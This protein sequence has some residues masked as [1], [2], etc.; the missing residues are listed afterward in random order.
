M[1]CVSTD[2]Q[3]LTRT[4]DDQVRINISAAVAQGKS[5]SQQPLALMLGTA[6]E[7]K[8]G[9]AAV[10][11]VLQQEGF[12]QQQA[13]R[14]VVTHAEISGKGKLLLAARALRELVAVRVKGGRP[15]VHAHCSS[16]ASFY[17][18]SVLLAL[19]RLMGCK[20]IF[21]LHGG[22]FR[23]FTMQEVGP[24]RRWWIRHTLEASSAV[25]A[26]SPSWAEFLTTFAP[27]SSV[28]VVPNSVRLADLSLDEKEEEGR[29]LF[30]GRIEKKKG[31]FELIEAVASLRE[32]HPSICLVL[33]GEGALGE[34]RA[35]AAELGIADR[36]ELPGWV[37]ASRRTLE[38]Q[39]A[40]LF[41]L[42]SYGEGL[43]MSMLEAMSAR[44][45]VVVTAVGGIP[46]AVED[47]VNGLL[48]APQDV[49]G[50]ATALDRL[51]SDRH[52]R[53]Q[54]ASA[55]RATVE[56]RFATS[57]MLDSLSNLYQCLSRSGR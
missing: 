27:R 47:G 28:M 22:E 45:A 21:H 44:K 39:R 33:G 56:Q 8:G 5:V 25:I 1:R 13:V 30:L 14:Y 41:A 10:V 35:R 19:A 53:E 17:R 24:L 38:M 15:I 51:L 40:C 12:L 9:V 18:K 26:L 46:E 50:L 2:R 11:C 4:I 34:A 23:Q 52:L 3:S 7:G 55:G 49:T 57:V 43:P 54:L 29:I 6:P 37:D 48:V 32:R 16:R 20:T 42:P 31:V 36:L